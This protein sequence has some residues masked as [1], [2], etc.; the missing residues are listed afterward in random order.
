M[1]P[2]R[3]AKGWREGLRQLLGIAEI[4]VRRYDFRHHAVSKA[5]TNPLVS[6][7]G[8]RKHFGW[9]DPRMID[10]YYHA[11]LDDFARGRGCDR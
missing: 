11:N 2:T 1:I 6:L 4:R 8:A 9:I 3:P 10:H 5:L 7:E